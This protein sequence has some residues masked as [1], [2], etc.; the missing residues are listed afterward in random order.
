MKQDLEERNHMNQY[1]W[2]YSFCISFTRGLNELITRSGLSKKEII[3]L[4]ENAA[5]QAIEE[6]TRR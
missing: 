6:K 1:Y 5:A 2:E 3:T 4:M